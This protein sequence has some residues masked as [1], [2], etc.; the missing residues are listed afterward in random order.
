MVVATLTAVH[1]DLT[2]Q[3]ADAIA[4]PTNTAVRGGGGVDAAIVLLDVLGDPP[5]GIVGREVL[6]RPDAFELYATGVCSVSPG[7]LALDELAT[8]SVA[9]SDD[10]RRPQCGRSAHGQRVW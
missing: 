2:R 10:R 1:G 4:N 7:R 9:V 3:D 5:L 6:V 8:Y